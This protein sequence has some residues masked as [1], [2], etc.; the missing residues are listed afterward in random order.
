MK[1]DVPLRDLGEVP[2][3]ALRDTVLGLDDTAWA[4][5]EYRQSTYEV[6]RQT[7][8]LVMVFTDGSGWPD[9]EV[10]RES[11]WD[12]L[13]DAALP[14]MNQLI[15]EHY[16]PGGTIIRAMAARMAPGAIINPH[17]DSH[18]SFHASHRI[19][20]PLATNPRVRFT[21]DGRPYKFEVGKAYEI[22]NQLMHSVMNKG[23]EHRVH[24]IFDYLPPGSSV[25]LH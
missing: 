3:E 1:I 19:H 22:N 23:Q 8:S 25:P 16:Q 12:W 15:A 2:S 6:H 21:I 7:E 14:L 18:P 24:F 10:T 17:R 11:G 13:A 4:D 5:H 9:I 20:V